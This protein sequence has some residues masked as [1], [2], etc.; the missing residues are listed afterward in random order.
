[1]SIPETGLNQI[2]RYGTSADRQLFVPNPGNLN[3]RVLYIW[4]EIDNPPNTYIW[5]G[6]A[7]V[8]INAPVD[9]SFF[10]QASRQLNNDEILAL[11]TTPL[12][13]VPAPGVGHYL[14]PIACVIETDFR[15]GYLGNVTQEDEDDGAS[16]FVVTYGENFSNAFKPMSVFSNSA[17]S[18]NNARIVAYCAP[19]QPVS[20][21]A[22]FPYNPGK[23]AQTY[24]YPSNGTDRVE[25][26]P[27]YIAAD[28][29]GDF[30]GGGA[31]N[32]M[33]VTI[34][35]VDRVFGSA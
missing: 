13:V 11:P 34:Y 35:Y 8:I 6:S 9:I 12:I 16:D 26:N 28:N 4:Y 23:F 24:G 10:L 5:N 29:S 2:I 33:T 21:Q 15:G 20:V 7:W 25:N 18:G 30:T 31:N 1:M 14:F 27:L 19:I 32:T 3:N 17:G 22:D